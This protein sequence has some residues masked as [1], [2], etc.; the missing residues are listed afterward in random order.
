V[1]PAEGR[2]ATD[3]EDQQAG[4]PAVDA[5]RVRGEVPGDGIGHEPGEAAAL[6]LHLQGPVHGPAQAGDAVDHQ[7]AH[8]DEG[9]EADDLHRQVAGEAG[10]QAGKGEAQE[11]GP[12]PASRDDAAEQHGM[13]DLHA[14]AGLE[15]QQV[16]GQAAHR[17]GA[18]PRPAPGH[19]VLDDDVDREHGVEAGPGQGVGRRVRAAPPFGHGEPDRAEPVQA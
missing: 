2:E 7:E 13:G 5:Q 11:K 8:G 4:V 1:R 18:V 14:Q 10:E 17:V 16:G 12:D 9:G 19:H 6:T 3:V 15:Q